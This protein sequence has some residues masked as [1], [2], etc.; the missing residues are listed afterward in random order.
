MDKSQL[1]KG[2]LEGCILKIISRAETYGYEIVTQ[3]EQHGFTDA[4][5]GT[6]YPLLLRLEKKNLVTGKFKPSPLGPKR[7]YY[8]L[9]ED[10]IAYVHNFYEAWCEVSD[11]V[12]SIFKEEKQ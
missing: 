2:I 4:K 3:L 1:M 12:E 7:K 9:T 11:S 10:G 6:L 8:Y 5:E